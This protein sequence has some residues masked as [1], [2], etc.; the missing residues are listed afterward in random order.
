MLLH[1][2][3]ERAPG[4]GP[5]QRSAVQA[6]LQACQAAWLGACAPGVRMPLFLIQACTIRS[7]GLGMTRNAA[8]ASCHKRQGWTFH[9]GAACL[10]DATQCVPDAMAEAG[11]AGGVSALKRAEP[12][13]RELCWAPGLC[14]L[15]LLP[16]APLGGLPT[17]ACGAA[18]R[19]CL[20]VCAQLWLH[21]VSAA[22]PDLP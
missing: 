13:A 15:S 1:A 16:L 21:R 5:A 4:G 19:P 20:A 7:G 14:A 3:A 8:H 12:A 2:A 10:A 6:A 11:L 18:G 9:A 17:V 22:W